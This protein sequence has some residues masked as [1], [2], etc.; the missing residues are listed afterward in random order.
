LVTEKFHLGQENLDLDME[1]Y[2]ASY[3]EW[4]TENVAELLHAETV[5]VNK[6]VGYAGT[7]DAVV[8]LKSDRIALIDTKTQG[9]KEGKKPAVYDTWLPQLRAYGSG[10]STQNPFYVNVV[11]NSTEPSPCLVHI[12]PEEE[13]Q[14]AWREFL[15]MHFIWCR[16]NRY[17]PTNYWKVEE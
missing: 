7:V 4:Y 16:S 14:L 11:I 3:K 17:W 12:W 5:L 1:P 9:V 13:Y 15:A 2:V 10:F 8:R 6:N